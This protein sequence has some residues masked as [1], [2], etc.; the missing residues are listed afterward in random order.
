MKAAKYIRLYN[1]VSIS[2]LSIETVLNGR[3]IRRM[4]Y[5]SLKKI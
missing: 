4:I 3:M 1:K 5:P 2:I